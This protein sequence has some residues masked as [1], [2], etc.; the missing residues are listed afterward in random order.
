MNE[1][2]ETLA[3]K[4]LR[5]SLYPLESALYDF[6][7][8][9]NNYNKDPVEH[10]QPSL[11]QSRAKESIKEKDNKAQDVLNVLSSCFMHLGDYDLIK[12]IEFLCKKAKENPSVK[13]DNTLSCRGCVDLIEK[14]LWPLQQK[15]VPDSK[16]NSVQ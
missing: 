8:G 14:T 4:Q 15:L 13:S 10:P 9:E 2:P 5:D 1:S 16:S 7:Y 6:W 11:D 12:E 3:R